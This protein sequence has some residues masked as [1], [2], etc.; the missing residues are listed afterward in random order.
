MTIKDDTDRTLYAK[1]KVYMPQSTDSLNN[2]MVYG[3]THKL[4]IIRDTSIQP[5]APKTETFEASIPEGI[6]QVRVI[7]ELSYQPRPGDVYP[8]H[9]QTMELESGKESTP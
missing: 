7:V 2:A 4:G 1:R 9:H 6:G 3:P 8:I 5:F